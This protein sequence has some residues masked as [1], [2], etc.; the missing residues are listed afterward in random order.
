MTRYFYSFLINLL[1]PF[2]ALAAFNEKKPDCNSHI[3]IYFSENKGQISDYNNKP[4]HEILF[5]GSFQNISFF[6]KNNG[7]SYQLYHVDSRKYEH[8]ND[9]IFKNTNSFFVQ[10]NEP[11]Q[12]MIDRLDINW[13]NCNMKASILKL[14]PRKGYDN[15]YSP[16]CPNGALN[17]LSYTAIIYQNIYKGINLKWYEKE[18]HL[19]YDYIIEKNVD[20]KQIQ[21]K[22]EGAEKISINNY[23]ELV[24]K[25]SMGEIVEQT[26]VVFQNNQ[27]LEAKWVLK[28]NI[29]CFE[30][31]KL[32]SNEP[33][34]IDPG[35]RTWGTYYGGT[36]N[37]DA[38]GSST[39]KFGNVYF[40]GVAENYSNNIIST[41]GSFQ[42]NTSG[43][44]AFLVKFDSSGQRLWGTY[45]A[46]AYQKYVEGN[47]CS[48]DLNG[49]I[50]LSGTTSSTISVATSNAYQTN[51]GGNSDAFLAKFNSAGVRIWS[52]Y[53]GGIGIE[54]GYDCVTDASGNIYMSGDS[55]GASNISTSNSHQ[56]NYGGGN[57]DAYLVKFNSN[58]QRLWCTYYGGSLT[59]EGYGCAT[60]LQGN[61]Y[62]TG[63]TESINSAN[64]A[65]SGSNQSI[66]TGSQSAFLVKF[67]ANGQR[68]WGTYYGD[69]NSSAYACA[70]D[71]RGNVFL[72]GLCGF[73]NGNSISTASSHQQNWGG[74]VWDAFLVK[75]NANGQRQWGT[76]YG[77]MGTDVSRDCV[78][79]SDDNV[80]ICGYTETNT[81]TVIA[82]QGTQQANMNGQSD[83]FIAGFGPDGQRH[84]GTYYGGPSRDHAFSIALDQH[85]TIYLAGLTDHDSGNS[86]ATTVSHQL[87]FGGREDAI[88]A[89]FNNCIIPSVANP[90]PNMSL[91]V[92]SNSL[93][94][95]Q[96][97]TISVSGASSYTWLPGSFQSSSL[98]LLAST[99][100]NYTIN[101]KD[102]QGCKNNI[103]VNI[104]VTPTP[105]LNVTPF[106]FICNSTAS[107]YA[108]G[109][110]TYT[111]S[112]VNITG[113]SLFVSPNVTMNYTVIGANKNCT[114]TAVSL[115]S[116]GIAPPLT[117]LTSTSS[118][119]S[120]SCFSFSNSS[121]QFSSFTYYW[122]D[123][124]FSKPFMT[125]HCYTASGKYQVF[126][127]ATYT[128]GCR[129]TS[130]NSLS[131]A[132]FALPKTKL[133]V[134][135]DRLVNANNQIIF[136]NYSLGAQ[137]FDW[138][139][140]DG[141]K[142]SN[143][144]SMADLNHVYSNS[145]LYCVK[146]IGRDTVNGCSDSLI[147]CVD[148]LCLAEITRPNIFTP[149]GDG[150]NDLF[151]FETNCIKSLLCT[152]YDRWGN[153]V[154]SWNTIK[155]SWN[156]ISMFHS[157]V[158]DGTY[159]YILEYIEEN[160][161]LVR[162]SGNI[163]VIR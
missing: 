13:M 94:S 151:K 138:F 22:I 29:A 101:G 56:P 159:Y 128:N 124:T 14:T 49:D 50:Y 148:V 140:G 152:I 120:G 46:G 66:F 44:G 24:L 109:A 15:Y 23:G 86:L 67:D 117:I 116:V 137:E 112:H 113:H 35:V 163:M 27:E 129:A 118:G 36:W 39:D 53:Y 106:S 18:G 11:E 74:A 105:T 65:S 37:E 146:L 8:T 157:E 33:F 88:F 147:Q 127:Q 73:N 45:Y 125:S 60:D 3:S 61:A 84:W 2:L 63:Y 97:V 139:F 32:N 99:N 19:K 142:I 59:E 47:S 70:V 1:T 133:N 156:G 12:V 62:L 104:P 91:V 123:S 78:I 40:A 107:I 79:D 58:G 95:G 76:Y 121:N 145:G 160:N 143:L 21:L 103:K 48:T 144:T 102:N 28:D 81:G 30:I 6:L 82:T 155:G 115:V 31:M 42:V 41:P 26:P 111:W 52:T 100:I 77:G 149:N 10:K 131:I 96:S 17:V 75:F 85:G 110:E 51:L 5:S 89:Q 54:R 108:T 72:T 141:I 135:D 71:Q 64:I 98:S 153:E 34:I 4:R 132:I 38:F 119:C 162:K 43:K 69:L 122:G 130:N 55:D 7:I 154:Y 25:T 114:S 57:Y 136:H 68:Q 150:V 83:A 16:S 80:Y 9:K 87:I 92:S 134:N 93:C 158:A 20:Y 126:A 90:V 161:T